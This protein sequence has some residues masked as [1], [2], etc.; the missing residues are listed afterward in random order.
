VEKGGEKLIVK[1]ERPGALKEGSLVEC[2]RPSSASIIIWNISTSATSQLSN[3]FLAW[4]GHLQ[5]PRNGF[6]VP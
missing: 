1:L 6:D 5:P 2:A 4:T 3:P